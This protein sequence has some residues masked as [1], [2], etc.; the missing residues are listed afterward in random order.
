METIDYL[1]KKLQERFSSNAIIKEIELKIKEKIEQKTFEL[2]YKTTL[3]RDGLEFRLL[4]VYAYFCSN[5]TTIES[6]KKIEIKL[7]FIC[8]SKLSKD[9]Q[10]RVSSVE[11]NYKK[12]KF[13]EWN[14]F[15]T[16]LWHELI[17]SLDLDQAILGNINL[18]IY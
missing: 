7:A 9:K 6:D 3:V 15:K 10:K 2:Y 17:Y 5:L 16:P 11:N 12:S 13:L 4:G 18:N 14:T 1:N 8:I